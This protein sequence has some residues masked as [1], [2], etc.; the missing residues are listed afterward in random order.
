MGKAQSAKS[1][2]EKLLSAK[3]QMLAGE[4][5]PPEDDLKLE[6]RA[7]AERPMPVSIMLRR[8]L[9]RVMENGMSPLRL[10]LVLG[11]SAAALCAHAQAPARDTAAANVP[12]DRGKLSYAIGYQIGNQFANGG[13]PNVDIQVLVKALQDGYAKRPPSVPLQDMREQ[14]LSFDAKVHNDAQAEFKRIAQANAR[15]SVAFLKRNGA[16]PGVISLPSGIQYT[17]LR[18]GGGTQ[19]PTVASTVTANYRGALTD[20]TE[21]DSSYAHGNPV[22][23][24]V[25][26]VIRGWQDV[27]PRMRVGDKWKVV[28][29]PQL[30]YGENGQLPRIGP[31]EALVFE[32]ELLEIKP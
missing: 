16:Q 1:H 28:I 32:I 26:G 7:P 23:F 14:L 30:A 13:P 24:T 25:N 4:P 15:K 10:V 27:I 18:K 29:P 2:G 3:R 20:G 31:N 22:T 17:V 5:F 12:V 6:V 21:F 19:A 11:L 8:R 9:C